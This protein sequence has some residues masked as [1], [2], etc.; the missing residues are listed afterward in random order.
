ML[1]DLIAHRA[2]RHPFIFA[3]LPT[4]PL[5]QPELETMEVGVDEGGQGRR[6]GAGV[7][8]LSIQV[9]LI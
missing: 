6:E 2:S 4:V 7:P 5:N 3:F 9:I 1:S 8:H